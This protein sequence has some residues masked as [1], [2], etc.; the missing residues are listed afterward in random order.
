M[1]G[2][3]NRKY[4]WTHGLEGEVGDEEEEREKTS[5]YLTIGD[6][7]LLNKHRANGTVLR[8]AAFIRSGH[9]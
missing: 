3:A 8:A 4:K 6:L 1:T 2:W 5:C 7:L 9:R